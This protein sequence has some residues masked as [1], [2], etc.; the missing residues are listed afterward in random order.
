MLTGTSEAR[1]SL[2]RLSPE[3]VVSSF[4]YIFAFLR[5]RRRSRKGAIVFHEGEIV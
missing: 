3:T 5:A 2:T 4:A 1:G